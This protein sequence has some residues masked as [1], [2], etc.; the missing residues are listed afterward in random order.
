MSIDT[1]LALPAKVAKHARSNL[2][3]V[4][5][6]AFFHSRLELHIKLIV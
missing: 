2:K 5:E 3:M 4:V 6:I 1:F